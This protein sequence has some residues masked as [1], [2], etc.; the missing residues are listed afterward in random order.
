MLK[1][2][3]CAALLVKYSAWITRLEPWSPHC[4]PAI[5]LQIPTLGRCPPTHIR[6]SPTQPV[7]LHL[8]GILLLFEKL[9][10]CVEGLYVYMHICPP[11]QFNKF[12]THLGGFCLF[13]LSSFKSLKLTLRKLNQNVSKLI[14]FTIFK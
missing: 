13:F 8:D 7:Q 10:K 1:K 5:W 12:L 9:G 14:F 4:Q 6:A 11:T 2:Q 3:H